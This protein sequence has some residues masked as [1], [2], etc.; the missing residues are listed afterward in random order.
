MKKFIKKLNENR[1]LVYDLGQK[2]YETVKDKYDLNNVSKL[3]SEF[4]KTL[5][6]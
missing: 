2:L 3:R 1:S 4:Y 6:N 5:I